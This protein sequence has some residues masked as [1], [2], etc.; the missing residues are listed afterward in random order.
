LLLHFSFAI[1]DAKSNTR[2]LTLN[3]IYMTFYFSGLTHKELDNCA[4]RDIP[5]KS[6]SS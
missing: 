5:T 1:L 4:Q 3:R 2:V 6:I